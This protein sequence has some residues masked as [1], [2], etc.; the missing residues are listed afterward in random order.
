MSNTQNKDT[1][2]RFFSTA[3]EVKQD[4]EKKPTIEGFAAVYGSESRNMGWF[5]E[6]IEPG[7]FSDVLGDDVRSLW[8][9]N[10]DKVLGRTKSGTLTITDTPSGLL[11]VTHPPDNTWGRDALVS[12]ERGDVDQMSFSFTVKEGGDSWSQRDDGVMVRR[13]LP[14]GAAGLYD[15]SPVTY[16]AYPQTSAAVRSKCKQMVEAGHIIED[17]EPDPAQVRSYGARY[18]LRLIE[19]EQ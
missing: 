16:P 13:L 3:M 1:E 8:N 7:F 5:V 2:R 15:I 19:S 10:D 11:T 14:G 17:T 12:M 6:I 9:H 4:E 18:Q